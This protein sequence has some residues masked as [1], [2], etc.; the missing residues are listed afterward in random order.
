MFQKVSKEKRCREIR[1]VSDKELVTVSRR[2]PINNEVF[3]T[4]VEVTTKEERSGQLVKDRQQAG[5]G[6]VLQGCKVL[7][8]VQLP[9]PVHGV[10]AMNKYVVNSA[11][12]N[13]QFFTRV[14]EL[15]FSKSNHELEK[16]SF[17]KFIRLLVHGFRIFK[18]MWKF[19][20]GLVYFTLMPTGF[21]FYRDALYVFLLKLF[22]PTLVLHLHGKGIQRQIAGSRLKRWLYRKVFHKTEVICLSTT[23]A[24]DV[25]EIYNGSPHIVPNGIPLQAAMTS[26]SEEKT[27]EKVPQ[28]LFLSNYI[29]NKGVLV[30]LQALAILKE[31]GY[32]FSARLVG[33][34]AH[35]SIETMNRFLAQYELTDMAEIVGPRYDKE[36][37][38]E[39]RKADI[40]VFPTYN[41]A[42]PLVILEAMQFSL[43]VV[44]TDE[45]GIP[46][47]VHNNETG[48]LVERRNPQMLAQK[49]AV[50]LENRERQR[51]MGQ[52]GYERFVSHFT[53]EHFERNL[54]STLTAILASSGS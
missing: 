17:Q 14:I 46:D 28:L 31:K 12:I 51:E 2:L 30:F 43:P 6:A 35:F 16:V 10:S 34:P 38:E 50:L 40:F 44:S 49:I 37:Y 29:E 18:T 1:G 13:E 20:P 15:K 26:P 24:A 47:I 9:P 41:D 23:L 11:V 39:F 52:E 8:I 22:S 42:F 36:K 19:R 21:G 27:P 54:K 3:H 53:L 48:F 5:Q 4:E 33:A 45:G 7:Y 32:R 25:A